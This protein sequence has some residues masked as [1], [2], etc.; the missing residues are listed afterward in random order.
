MSILPKS[1]R[2]LQLQTSI[3]RELFATCRQPFFDVVH[4]KGKLAVSLK[5][6]I[7]QAVFHK[8]DRQHLKHDALHG[9]VYIVHYNEHMHETIFIVDRRNSSELAIY[10]C[11]PC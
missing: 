10:N 3:I 4:A 5:T 1:R 7:L 11:A 6:S 2:A 8:G 9:L